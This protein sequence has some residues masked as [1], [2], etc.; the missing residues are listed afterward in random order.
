MTNQVETSEMNEYNDSR[1]D[2]IAAV[3]LIFIVVATTVF[4]VSGQ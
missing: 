1:V 3:S 2:A 4:W